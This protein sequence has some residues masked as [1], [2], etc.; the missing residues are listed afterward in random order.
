[1]FGV[2][3]KHGKGISSHCKQC[4]SI[5]CCKRWNAK[6]IAVCKFLGDKC[7]KCNLSFPYQVYNFHHRDPSS[8]EFDWS[9]LR[10]RS[11]AD[12]M[13][14]ID[15]CDLVCANCHII[16]HST[17]P[18]WDETQP[19]IVKYLKQMDILRPKVSPQ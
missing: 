4:F 16:E 11:T 5:F 1:M 9:K 2:H 12:I 6:K 18:A 7:S 13:T 3:N 14:E 17:S 10:L 8:K 15:K 19:L